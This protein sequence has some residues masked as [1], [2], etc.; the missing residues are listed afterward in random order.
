MWI[1]FDQN[2][3]GQIMKNKSDQLYSI[4][5]VDKT[6]NWIPIKRYEQSFSVGKLLIS[7]K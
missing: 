6:K 7:T 4:N 1:K 3:V 2:R 5:K